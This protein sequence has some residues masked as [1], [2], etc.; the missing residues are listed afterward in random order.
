MKSIKE[1]EKEIEQ[2][3]TYFKFWDSDEHEEK[4]FGLTTNEDDFLGE[5][6]MGAGEMEIKPLPTNRKDRDQAYRSY[7]KI[8]E[9]KL[10]NPYLNHSE[11]ILIA[12]VKV[13][14]HGAS[15]KFHERY[16]KNS[17]AVKMYW[18]DYCQNN[19]KI[20]REYF[21]KNL[22][23]NQKCAKIEK[24]KKTKKKSSKNAR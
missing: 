13:F 14:S 9:F 18:R 22:E 6:R 10:N 15:K 1:L 21:D 2:A 20:Y 7:P 19:S 16:P 4:K 3:L 17:E 5:I 8:R 23:K 12:G 11:G 24:K